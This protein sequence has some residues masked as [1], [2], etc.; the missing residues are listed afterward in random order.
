LDGIYEYGCDHIPFAYL[1]H[2]SRWIEFDT[3]PPTKII[4]NYLKKIFKFLHQ[5]GNAIIRPTETFSF[6]NLKNMKL[7]VGGG[8]AVV[9]DPIKDA[10]HLLL[11]GSDLLFQKIKKLLEDEN[12][13]SAFNQVKDNLI[14]HNGFTYSLPSD[15]E[16]F[17]E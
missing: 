5:H 9:K 17:G 13:I 15:E 7:L 4:A 6:K 1:Y 12:F 2:H 3:I 11:N 16:E 14:I 10:F 8:R